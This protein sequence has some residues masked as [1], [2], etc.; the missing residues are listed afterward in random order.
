MKKSSLMLAALALT[1]IFGGIVSA[2]A[3]DCDGL[4]GNA[5]GRTNTDPFGS[6]ENS[7][8]T[9]SCGAGTDAGGVFTLI[10][11]QGTN[12][13]VQGCSGPGDTL[14]IGGRVGVL[15]ES[16]ND[17]SVHVDGSDS[18][19]AGGAKGWQRYDV[20]PNEGAACAR[21]SGGG[22]WWTG[23]TSGKGASTVTA[24]NGNFNQGIDTNGNRTPCGGTP[25]PA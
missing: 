15:L 1:T 9:V 21:R 17:A 11:L 5:I 7:S 20:R 23:A 3:A 13:G 10:V 8:G 4:A 2:Q 6:C 14:P 16:D 25:F 19:N 12:K 24:D 22:T 18:E